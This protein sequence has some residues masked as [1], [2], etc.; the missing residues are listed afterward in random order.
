[1][2]SYG[3]PSPRSRLIVLF[4]AR[5]VRFED[6]HIRRRTPMRPPPPDTNNER[7][8]STIA[9]LRSIH[10]GERRY[11]CSRRR[12]APSYPHRSIL[13]AT[14]LVAAQLLGGAFSAAIVETPHSTSLS[15][16]SSLQAPLRKP[17]SWLPQNYPATSDWPN[18]HKPDYCTQVFGPMADDSKRINHENR[19]SSSGRGIELSSQSS[20]VT[21]I[22]T[23]VERSHGESLDPKQ[24]E[25]ADFHNTISWIPSVNWQAPSKRQTAE[26]AY[27]S[28]M[29]AE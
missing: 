18:V 1:M 14:F 24:A 15:L 26:A 3:H 27:S 13:P 9:S 19:T 12:H 28:G 20:L 21:S 16:A 11:R 6:Y 4:S 7:P 23:E 8:L 10:Q 5:A 2:R 22:R 29:I 25:R 17:P